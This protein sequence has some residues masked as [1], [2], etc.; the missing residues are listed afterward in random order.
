MSDT[1]NRCDKCDAPL[2]IRSAFS[3]L[4]THAESLR[5]AQR[6]YMANRGNEEMGREVARAAAALDEAIEAARALQ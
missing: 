3:N 5:A 4:L 6:A 2:L 1:I